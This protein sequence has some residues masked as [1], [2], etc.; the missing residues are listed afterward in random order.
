MHYPID[1][2]EPVAVALSPDLVCKLRKNNHGMGLS[3]TR[4]NA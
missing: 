4:R 3:D 2:L 1:I